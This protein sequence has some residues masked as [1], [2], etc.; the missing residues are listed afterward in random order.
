MTF[1][2]INYLAVIVAAIASFGFGALYYMS[3]AGPWLAAIGKTKEE[4]A[5]NTS[6]APFII[7]A[8]AELIMAWMVAGALGHLGSGQVTIWNGLVTG[9]L[10]WFGFVLT[11]LVVNHAYQGSKRAH[12]VIDACHW[13]GVLIIQGIVIGAFGV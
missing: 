3:L 9:V 6:K 1:A 8:V 7:S 2:G 12:T 4:L 5:A 11:T 13:L 10:L